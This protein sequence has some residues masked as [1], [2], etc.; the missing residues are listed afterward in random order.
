MQDQIF[1]G[2]T[3]TKQELITTRVIG[4]RTNST[5]AGVPEAILPI[6]PIKDINIISRATI[7][8]VSTSPAKE[9][10]IV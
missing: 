3:L 5:A 4:V 9:D 1:N 6:A 10:I 2:D 8:A 7:N